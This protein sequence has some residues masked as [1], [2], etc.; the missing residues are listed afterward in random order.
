MNLKSISAFVLDMDGVITRGDQALPGAPE[1][2]EFLRLRKYP[3]QVVTNNS[4][5][6]SQQVAA[7]FERMAIRIEPENI[8]TSSMGAALYLKKIRPDGARVYVIGE[9]GLCLP[10]AAA[11]F[12]LVE[13][14]SADF[15]VVGMDRKLTYDKLRRATLLI[16]AKAGFIATNPDTTFPTADGLVPGTGAIVAA[17]QSATG[18]SPLIIGKPEPACFTMAIEKMGRRV[19]ETA[20]IGDR[21]DTDIEGGRRAGMPTILVLTGVTSRTDLAGIPQ[22][23]DW[24]FNDLDELRR[25]LAE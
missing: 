4:T 5:R 19:A 11:G 14:G 12:T 2:L 21:L 20:A 22:P 24:V 10:L 23:A 7:R 1:F 17:L 3:Y 25:A 18:V 16:R 6:T 15:V 8:L 9:E 13:E